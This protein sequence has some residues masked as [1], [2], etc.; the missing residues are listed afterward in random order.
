MI[1]PRFLFPAV[2]AVL[3]VA[4]PFPASA[5]DAADVQPTTLPLSIEKGAHIVI[6]GG[7][8]HG[9]DAGAWVV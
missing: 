9:A 8:A 2:V 4:Y 6:L 7:G 1:S 5:Q 3:S